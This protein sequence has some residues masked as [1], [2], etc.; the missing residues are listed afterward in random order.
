MERRSAWSIGV[1]VVLAVH[2]CLIALLLRAIDA[3]APRIARA[4]G[5]RILWLPPLT[6]P[7]APHPTHAKPPQP[8]QTSASRPSAY[9]DYRGITLTPDVLAN[10]TPGLNQSLF[11]CDG[12]NREALTPQERAHCAAAPYG[13]HPGNGVDWRDHTP[14]S[15]YAALWAQG[16]D[17]K[18]APLLLP[19]MSPV[20]FSPLAVAACA[21]KAV[22]EGRIKPDEQSSYAD[23]VET[24][25]LPNNGD[26]PDKPN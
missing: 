6:P 9:P 15:R 2:A 11:G 16:R 14:D 20:G 12:T 10:R 8:G 21:A 7:P 26:P 5:E 23:K 1:L 13:M 25:H 19:C 18:N 17:R 3:P 4:E 24:F 22:V